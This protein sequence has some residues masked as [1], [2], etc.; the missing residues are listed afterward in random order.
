LTNLM[1]FQTSL[2]LFNQ[3]TRQVMVSNYR[4]IQTNLVILI[5]HCENDPVLSIVINRLKAN[6]NI[7]LDE[8]YDK[9]KDR[10]N[11]FELP[12][13]DENR[14]ALLYQLLSKL[15][16]E[17]LDPVDVAYELF[18]S[19][20]TS[21]DHYVHEFSNNIMRPFINGMRNALSNERIRMGFPP[22]LEEDWLSTMIA[23]PEIQESLKNFRQDHS[24]PDKVGFIM[25]KFKRTTAHTKIEKAIKETLRSYGLDGVRSDD[26]QYHDDLLYNVLTYVHGCAF[27]V[28][29]FERI[30]EEEF[31][32]N[33]S[34][35]VGYV[36]ALGKDLCL[37]KDKNLE[38]LHADLLGK[39]YKEFD[40]QD[41]EGTIPDKLS[42]WL[43]DK[44]IA[45]RI[46]TTS[47]I[48]SFGEPLEEALDKDLPLDIMA[49]KRRLS[50]KALGPVRVYR[51]KDG[52]FVIQYNEV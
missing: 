18:P 28:A 30:E 49:E 3:D 27:G 15:V 29:V 6:R 40:P 35:E 44:G 32:P 17:K 43:S 5:D 31:S 16:R 47:L 4:A 36:M 37:L 24:D 23:V 26:K 19:R 52:T 8:W 41:P 13:D 14:L 2:R 12:K 45:K 21:L 48:E 42:K 22:E 11:P 33:V 51:K 25:M 50:H 9:V 34:L 46:V 38:T 39:L 10:E 1:E 7:N 20:I